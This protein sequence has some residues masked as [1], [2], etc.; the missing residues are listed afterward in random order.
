CQNNL[1]Q[2]GLAVHNYHDTYQFLPPYRLADNWAT[3]WVLILPHLEQ[4]NVYKLW[5]LKLRYYL[6]SAAARQNNIK[7]YFCPSRRSPPTVFSNDS[8][9]SAI[10][11]FPV[12]PGGLGDYAV[13]IGPDYLTTT[14]EGAII[15]ALRNSQAGFPCADPSTGKPVNDTGA[16]SPPNAIL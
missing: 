4:D 6:Q 10:P 13:C 5:D 14:S 1:K 11:S 3:V 15:E 8:R 16:G 7:T 12:T 2:I 9:L